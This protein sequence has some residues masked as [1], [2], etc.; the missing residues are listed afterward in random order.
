MLLSKKEKE[1]RVIELANQRKTTREIAKE[2]RISL[3]TIG[4]I[5]NKATGDDEAEKEQRLKD[6]SDYA[7]PFKMFQDGRPLTDVAIELDIESPTVICYYRDYLKLVNMGRLVTIYK[8]LKDDLSLFLRLYGR[9]KEERLS[10]PQLVEL[11]KTPNR[12]LDLGKKVDLYNNHIWNL[13]E[14]KLKLEKEIKILSNALR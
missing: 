13:H 2:V 3:R 9:I 4:K 6:K 11:L 5:L 14:K 1:K 7:R 8:E 12:I 10:K